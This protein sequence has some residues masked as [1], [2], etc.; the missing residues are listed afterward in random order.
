MDDRQIIGTM[1]VDLLAGTQL[2]Y[3]VP[4]MV[5]GIDDFYSHVQVAI[6]THGYTGF[7]YNVKNVVDHL[8]SNGITVI[9]GERRSIEDLEGMSWNLRPTLITP[10]RVPTRVEIN[11]RLDRTTSLRFRS[12]GNR[13][14]PPRFLVDSADRELHE[15]EEHFV[16]ITQN[17][18]EEPLN[19]KKRGCKPK[20]NKRKG[21]EN[22]ATL[23]EYFGKWD[24]YVNYSAPDKTT[25]IDQIIATGWDEYESDQWRDNLDE[26]KVVI[27]EEESDE[28]NTEDEFQTKLEMLQ[29]IAS[30]K[31]SKEQIFHTTIEDEDEEDE[32]DAK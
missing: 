20:K 31:I 9:P 4:D 11:Q 19:K 32:D 12:Y 2:I 28:G 25:P 22:W 13:P 14:Q 15:D 24:Y 21:W 10:T 8:A 23:G 5:L 6:Q 16:G 17:I 30:P 27:H 7:Q 18:E 29:M 3:M 1:E 26:G